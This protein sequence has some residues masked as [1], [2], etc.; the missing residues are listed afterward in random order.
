MRQLVAHGVVHPAVPRQFHGTYDVN[1]TS[2]SG[3]ING[4]ATPIDQPVWTYVFGTD[5]YV[6]VASHRLKF[7][8]NKPCRVTVNRSVQIAPEGDKLYVLDEDE[9]A[10]DR[11]AH[12]PA[13]TV[14][15]GRRPEFTDCVKRWGERL[16]A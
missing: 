4:T 15:Y 13:Y 14:R 12:P 16:P 7:R 9:K 3:H 5:E 10:D 11:Q 2:G 8:W 6:Y 1:G